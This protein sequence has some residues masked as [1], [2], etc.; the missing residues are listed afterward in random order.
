MLKFLID[1]SKSGSEAYGKLLEEE[2]HR[3]EKTDDSY[4]FHEHLE[5]TNEPCYFYEFLEAAGEAELKYI[6]DTSL[7]MMVVQHFGKP[8]TDLLA[9]VPLLQ[10]EQYMDFLRGRMFRASLVARAT[11]S[12]RYDGSPDRLRGLS[13]V[14]AEPMRTEPSE[15]ASRPPGE[16]TWRCESGRVKTSPELAPVV[17]RLNERWPRWTTPEELVSS[18]GQDQGEPVAS[19][20]TVYR[21]LLSMLLHGALKIAVEPPSILE[22]GVDN[23]ATTPLMRIQAAAG[24][25]VTNR[26]HIDI[27]LPPLARFLARQLDG[28]ATVQ[29]VTERVVDAVHKGELGL[30]RRGEPVTQLPLD[31]AKQLVASEL[32]MLAANRMLVDPPALQGD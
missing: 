5:A 16:I 31:T 23:P 13:V 28:T 25:K 9:D 32:A 12:P 17:E 2:A 10:R 21:L 7:Q 27:D 6:A 15:D 14:L 8:V 30:S 29:E 24:T 20:S 11:T 18:L 1:S 3:L 19:E 26:A 22:R 4:L